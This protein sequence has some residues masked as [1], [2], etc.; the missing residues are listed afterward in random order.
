MW[1]IIIA[2]VL[3]YPAVEM[4]EEW[5]RRRVANR[6]L[7]QMREHVQQRHQWDVVRGQWVA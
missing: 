6:L 7:K 4:A 1:D 2:L 5:R 3:L